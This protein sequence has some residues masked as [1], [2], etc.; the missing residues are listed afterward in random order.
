MAYS[1]LAETWGLYA[2]G[3]LIFL[4]RI[5]CRLRAVGLVGF[6]PDDYIVFLSWVRNSLVTFLAMKFVLFRLSLVNI[7]DIRL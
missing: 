6:K 4:A 5:V 2:G 1:P 7:A 3:S